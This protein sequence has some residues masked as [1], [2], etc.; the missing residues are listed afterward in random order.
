MIKVEL[1]KP[2]IKGSGKF[3]PPPGWKY[4]DGKWTKIN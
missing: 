1:V 3:I 2:E 4:V